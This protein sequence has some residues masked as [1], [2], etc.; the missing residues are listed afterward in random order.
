MHWGRLAVRTVL[1]AGPAKTTVG[2]LSGL[3]LS[4]GDAADAQHDAQPNAH[5]TASL[6]ADPRATVA[7]P[8]LHY[9]N[10]SVAMEGACLAAHEEVR[11]AQL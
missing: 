10:R 5:V 1:R 7:S 9:A 8:S 6:H 11:S 3:V 2:P 4:G